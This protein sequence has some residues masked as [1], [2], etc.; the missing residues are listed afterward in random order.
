MIPRRP[1]RAPARACGPRFPRGWFARTAPALAPP[2]DSGSGRST[3]RCALG[4]EAPEPRLELI[5]VALVL[6]RRPQPAARAPRRRLGRRRCDLPAARRF[7]RRRAGRFAWGDDTERGPWVGIGVRDGE[8]IVERRPGW[9]TRRRG[10]GASR[11][12]GEN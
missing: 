2:A 3:R 11:S 10:R 4:L 12:A 5:E 8:H 9:G 6:D 7:V 1:A